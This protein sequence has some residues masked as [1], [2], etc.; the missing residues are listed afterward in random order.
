MRKY[1]GITET[2]NGNEYRIEIWDEPSGLATGGTQLDMATPG[3]TID[4]DGEGDKLWENPLR[5]S[6]INAYF[7][8]SDTTDHDFFQSLAVA[9]EGKSA[10]V[11]YKN[12]DIFYVGRIIPDGMQYER[13]PEKNT[14][15][16]IGAVDGLNLLDKYK[17]DYNWFDSNTQRLDILK[18]VRESLKLTAI[19]DYYDHLGVS[20]DYMVDAS[21]NF[22]TGEFDRLNVLEINLSSVINDLDE[23]MLQTTTGGTEV[24]YVD[25]K[26]AIERVLLLLH[27]RLIYANGSFYIFDPVDYGSNYQNFGVKYSTNGTQG[28]KLST[29]PQYTISNGTRP[30]FEAFPIHSHQP[31][32]REIRQNY[33]REAFNRVVRNQASPNNQPITITTPSIG[34][35]SGENRIFKVSSVLQYFTPITP[36]ATKQKFIEISFRAYVTYSGGYKHYNYQ[37][38]SWDLGKTAVP[39]FEKIRAAVTGYEK[40]N[41]S[42][43]LTIDFQRE[44]QPPSAGDDVTV[45]ISV[46]TMQ[47]SWATGQ[48]F[49]PIFFTGV[50]CTYEVDNT[51][52]SV[53]K[54]NDKYDINQDITISDKVEY[55]I[56]YG[57]EYSGNTVNARGT[58]WNS[59]TNSASGILA[60][61]WAAKQL[62]CYIDAPKTASATLVDDGNYYPIL[63]PQFDSDSYVF[64]GGTFNAQD[65]I[66]EL[67]LL[68]IEEDVVNVNS[69][70]LDYQDTI[71]GTGQQRD[72]VRR[73]LNQTNTLRDSVSSFDTSLPTD[74]MRLSPDTPTTQPT[75]DTYFNPVIVYDATDD[76]LEW[77]IQEMGKVQSLTGG[78]HN[79]D[80]SAE[81]VV[82]DSSAENIIITLPSPS[83]VKGRKYI[84]KKISSSHNVQ[85]SGTIDSAPSYSFNSLWESIT[86]M[87]DGTEYYAVGRYH[88]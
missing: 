20:A 45:D 3:F 33:T 28:A 86:I 64:S 43:R 13:R 29:L 8:V 9:T 47:W 61:E 66:W 79:L 23:F 36:Q 11:V 49:N 34:A 52:K 38:Q 7:I 63:S 87:S 75:I 30:T 62:A 78:T 41:S 40:F 25:C 74:I 16:Q 69:D 80:V 44:F 67:E 35:V 5:N 58:L 59:S 24:I 50:L 73:V 37:T 65:E 83:L 77:N 72:A 14:V 42:Y 17:V 10:I 1:Y 71:G 81:L 55:E 85:L 32:V 4:Y 27:C 6:R 26:T 21:K 31:A 56:I 51:N 53:I 57:Y 54:T 76:V 18:L 60:G 2:I 84:F 12:S 68:K 22:P 39:V 70:E 82:C 46:G 48:V 19:P 15:Y 88:S